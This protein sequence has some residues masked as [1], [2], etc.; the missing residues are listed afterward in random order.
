ML[1]FCF[2]QKTAY[3]MRISDWS[4]DVCSSDLIVVGAGKVRHLAQ[5]PQDAAL[6]RRLGLCVCGA[7]RVHRKTQTVHAGIEC[8]KGVQGHGVRPRRRGRK[9][10][11]QLFLTMRSDEHTYELKSIMRIPYA[12]SRL[13]EKHN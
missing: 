9:Q 13:I 11:I 2:N 12:F 8:Y 10:H 4:S 1:L 7:I 5:R 3:E 6:L